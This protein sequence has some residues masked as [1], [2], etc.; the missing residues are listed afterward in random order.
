MQ[1]ESWDFCTNRQPLPANLPI[2]STCQKAGPD[3]IDKPQP[4][5]YNTGRPPRLHAFSKTGH[6][7]TGA[8]KQGGT[9]RVTN[10]D[11][12]LLA[13]IGELHRTRSVSQ[14]AERLE[15]SQ[16]AI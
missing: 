13:V 3:V 11:L 15:L 8:A 7:R 4:E 12:K 14:A 16:S 10:I 9:R 1:T 2:P 6:E 5:E